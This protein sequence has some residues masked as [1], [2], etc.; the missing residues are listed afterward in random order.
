LPLAGALLSLLMALLLARGPIAAVYVFALLGCALG[1]VSLHL[2]LVTRATD[3]ADVQAPT[4]QDIGARLEQR[5]EQ[6]QDLRWELNENESRYRALLDSQE[7]MISRRDGSGRLT[8][9]NKAF[10]SMFAVTADEV[11][12]NPF[13]VVVRE[14]ERP[15]PLS[16]TGEIRHQ[17]FTQQL[18]TAAGPRWIEW[19]EQLA[20][21][22][23]GLSL[24][25]QS[26]G[27]DVTDQRHVES[28]LAE[29]RDQAEAANRAKSRFLAAMSRNPHA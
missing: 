26:I 29:A 14:G 1:L 15:A 16:T 10:L 22:A 21:A 4:M 12:G 18:Q 23:D 9:V 6:L 11:L 28:Q 17:R 5:L 13:S 2:A 3:T 19:E 25:V 24:E 20:P 8:F 27:R 7:D